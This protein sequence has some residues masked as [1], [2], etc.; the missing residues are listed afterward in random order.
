MGVW[1]KRGKKSKGISIFFPLPQ[2]G[3]PGPLGLKGDGGPFFGRPSVAH[4]G[5]PFGA[6]F[7]GGERKTK[8]IWGA[9]NFKNKFLKTPLFYKRGGEWGLAGKKGFT[10]EVGGLDW[11]FFLALGGKPGKNWGAPPFWAVFFFFLCGGRYNF[12]LGKIFPGPGFFGF[13]TL[14]PK[15]PQLFF[16]VFLE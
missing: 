15:F 6:Q 11:G 5:N 4:R 13:L 3:G 8:K 2:R 12:F 7:R 9:F 1:G 14:F 10:P 16:G